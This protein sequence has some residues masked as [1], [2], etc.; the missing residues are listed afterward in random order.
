MKKIIFLGT[1]LSTLTIYSQVGINTLNPQ[2]ELHIDGAKDGVNT[3]DFVAT[4]SGN[5]GVGTIS[6]SAPVLFGFLPPTRRISMYSTGNNDHQYLGLGVIPSY[7]TYQVDSSVSN[8]V[9]RSGTGSASSNTLATLTGDGKLGLGTALPT[10]MLTVNGGKFQYLDGTQTDGN[11]LTSDSNGV[12]SWQRPSSGTNTVTMTASTGIDIPSTTGSSYIQT[13]QIVVLPPGK[14][15]V[16]VE[17]LLTENLRNTCCGASTDINET[18]WVRSSF[19]ESSSSTAV[20]PDIE[21]HQYISGLLT[22]SSRFGMLKGSVVINNTSGSNK[23]YYYFG[24][25]IT[26]SNNPTGSLK[27]FGANAG[28]WLEDNISYKKIN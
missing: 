26:G 25:N 2:A 27:G 6:P 28:Y 23:T 21:S 24:G 14:W 10:N 12:A 18:W 1:L 16:S 22:S 4:S 8:F 19:S 11:V 17:M 13:G 15:L 3:N 7:S 20:S 5:V 9:W